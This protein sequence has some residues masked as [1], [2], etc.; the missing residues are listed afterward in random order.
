MQ[1]HDAIMTELNLITLRDFFPVCHY[2][3]KTERYICLFSRFHKQQ[4]TI[5]LNSGSMK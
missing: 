4:Y 5:V 2:V 1:P 3:Y